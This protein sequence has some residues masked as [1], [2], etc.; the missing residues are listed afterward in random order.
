MNP[1]SW[2]DLVLQPTMDPRSLIANPVLV[3]SGATSRDGSFLRSVN[4]LQSVTWVA[5]VIKFTPSATMA[6]YIMANN[7]QD[8]DSIE[9][10]NLWNTTHAMTSINP[11]LPLVSEG[12]IFGKAG[13][14]SNNNYPIDF[15][16]GATSTDI[17]ISFRDN[18][19]TGGDFTSGGTPTI[20]VFAF[21]SATYGGTSKLLTMTFL[22][23]GRFSLGIRVVDNSGNYSMFPIELIVL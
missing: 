9:A 15:I 21:P 20:P 22:Q 10:A 2:N 13:S 12:L 6:A 11:Q 7:P 8:F 18:S 3:D 17:Q 1:Q 23:T 5:P 16:G 4:W 14:N 19:F